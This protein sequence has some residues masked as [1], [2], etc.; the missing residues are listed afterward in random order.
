MEVVIIIETDVFD[1]GAPP[2]RPDAVDERD[3]ALAAF[4]D[5]NVIRVPA[6]LHGGPGGRLGLFNGGGVGIGFDGDAVVRAQPE[7]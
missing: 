5:L 7:M 1:H 3:D 2:V 6:R 4:L